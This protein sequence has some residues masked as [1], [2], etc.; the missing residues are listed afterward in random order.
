MQRSFEELGRPLS[1]VTFPVIDLETTGGSPTTCAITEVGAVKL[2]GGECVGTFQTLVNPGVAIPPAIVYLTGITDAMVLPAPPVEPVLASLLEFI[3]DSVIVG[4]NVRFDV[5]F[6]DA[7]LR[8]QGDARLANPTVD[9]CALARRLVRD[10][11]PDCKLATLARHFR[12]GHQPSHRALDDALA[13][14]DLLHRLLER[15]GSLGVLG[16]DDLLLLPRMGGHPQAAKLRMTTSLPRRPGV[17]LF[18]DQAGNV[19]Y[20]G[21][22][23]NLRQRVRSYFSTDERRKIGDLLRQAHSVDHVVC[24]GQL[25]AAAVE[26][27]LIHHL[28]PRYNRQAKAWRH[29]VYVRLTLDERYPKLSVVRAVRPGDGCLYLGPMA[30]A[31]AAR[32]VTDAIETA[33]PLRRCRAPIAR[34]RRPGSPPPP[35]P[36]RGLGVR[37]CPCDGT[38]S[39]EDYRAVVD[40][41]VRGLT[42]DPSVLIEPLVRRLETLSAAHRFEEAA[43]LR[44]RAGALVR[45]LTR[46]RRIDALRA[47]GRI[48]LRTREGAEA[49][50]VDGRL[51]EA[52]NGERP[53]MGLTCA[54]TDWGRTAAAHGPAPE[55]ESSWPTPVPREH[56]DEVL[57]VAAWL[58]ANAGTVTLLEARHGLALP[59]FPLPTFSPGSR[60]Q[61]VLV[62]PSPG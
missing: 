3:G 2:R 59:A 13:T 6:L 29:Y 18:R 17:Y 50:I 23:A 45:A 14:G 7:A 19:L 53:L 40:T 31:S 42:V 30:S 24:S 51:A 54:V 36:T 62:V 46:Q 10:E 21:K 34:R 11:V 5:G 57:A 32:L 35:C 47:A 16:L 52:W 27:R 41:V 12:L 56:A 61:P 43:E 33:M 1:E 49:T 60:P 48:V 4:H 37:P 9:T 28:S 39:D 38:V 15:A 22:A 20:V 44:D 26:T 8:R 58:D 55:D 25:E